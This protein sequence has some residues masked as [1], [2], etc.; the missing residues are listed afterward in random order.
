MVETALCTDADQSIDALAQ[1]LMEV[2]DLPLDAITEEVRSVLRRVLAEQG[3]NVD[4]AIAWFQEDNGSLCGC[5][6]L[7]LVRQ[8]QPF[9]LLD[10]AWADCDTRFGDVHATEGTN[11][12]D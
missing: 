11:G 12:N 3:G 6:P 2:G 7:W 4:A 5:S 10:T 9:R 8:R 1:R